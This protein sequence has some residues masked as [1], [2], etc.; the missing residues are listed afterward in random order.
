MRTPAQRATGVL[1]C[2]W[3]VHAAGAQTPDTHHF[4]YERPVTI[5]AGSGPQACAILDVPLYAHAGPAINDLRLYASASVSASTEI[6]YV[7]LV[8]NSATEAS[9]P[10]RILNLGTRSGRIVFDLDMPARPYTAVDLDLAAHDFLATAKVF[11]ETPAQPPINLGVYTLYDLTAQRLS[12][13]TTLPLAESTFPRLHIELTLTP[14]PGT[15]AAAYPPSIVN[16]ASV[17]PSRQAQTLYTTVAETAALTHEDR[18][19]IAR[20]RIPARVPVERVEFL[21]PESFHANFSRTVTISARALTP[22]PDPDAAPEQLT[23]EI[24]RV[25]LTQ[26][27]RSIHQQ[28]LTVPAILGANLQHDAQVEVAI[29]DGDDRPLPIAAVRLEMRRRTLCFDA[30]TTQLVQ[31][32]Y[33][34]PALR[35]PVYDYARLYTQA[36]TPSQATLGPEQLNP[37]YTPRPDTRAFT[38]RHPELLWLVLI[39]VILTLGFIAFR[40]AK[41]LPTST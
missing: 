20:F 26:L 38:E 3:L 15:T 17:P 24:S 18:S 31:L 8:S 5:G 28:Q 21:L 16:G 4:L 2:L 35:A 22:H 10:A 11:G 13:N 12:R 23:G 33:G 37:L 27:G 7:L 39:A 29:A 40:S 19:T 41:R 32:F 25:Q 6:P 1:L 36:D 9:E 34:D 14:A 30:P